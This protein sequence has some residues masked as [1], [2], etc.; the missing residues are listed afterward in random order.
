MGPAGS[1]APNDQGS[2][3][4][5]GREPGGSTSSIDELVQ[6]GP[7]LRLCP[8]SR[9]SESL[10]PH[11]PQANGSASS[12]KIPVWGH[13]MQE[14]TTPPLAPKQQDSKELSR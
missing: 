14:V 4:A 7:G 2:L 3:W 12:Q 9:S 6:R 13:S 1:S 8:A 11:D 5:V 10:A